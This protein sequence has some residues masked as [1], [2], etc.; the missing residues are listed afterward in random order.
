M[1]SRVTALLLTF[2]L[3]ALGVGNFYLGNKGKG[4]AQLALFVGG[5]FTFGILSIVLAIWVI[6]DFVK[7]CITPD[8]V[9]NKKYNNKE[10]EN[11]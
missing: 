6:F 2:F 3:G 7:L 9:F 4:I 11:N 8:A 1:K 5:F 10:I